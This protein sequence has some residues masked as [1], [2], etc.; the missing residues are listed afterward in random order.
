MTSRNYAIL[1]RLL[2]ALLTVGLALIPIIRAAAQEAAN[3]STAQPTKTAAADQQPEEV[4]LSPFVVSTD[5]D[6]GYGATNSISGSRVD[7]AIKDIPISINVI[8]SDFI[9]DIGATD[10]RSSLMYTSGVMLTTQNDLENTAGTYGS[11]YG[12]GGVNNPQGLTANINQVQFKIR[13]FITNNTLRDGFL[14]GSGTDAVNIERIEVVEGPNALLYGTG[15]FGG[16]VDYLTK[17]PSEVQQGAISVSYGTYSF[18]RSELDVTGPVSTANHIAYRLGASWESSE[19]NI[20]FQK[21][22]HY[23]IAPSLSWKPT[24]TTLVTLDTEYGKSKQNGY[25]FQA[26]RAAQ[27]TAGTP[28]N[29]DQLEAVAFYYP[30]GADPKTV[31]LSG[32]DTYNDQQESNIEIK[33][34]QQLLKESTYLP[35]VDFLLGYDRSYW[36]TQTQDV[37]GQITGPISPGNPG[38]NLSQTIV[39]AGVANGLGGQDVA[40]LSLVFGTFP[41]SV[42][43]YNWNQNRQSTN[44]EQE[45]AELTARKI[46]FEGKW[47]RVED[48]VLAGFSQL[49]NQVKRN[50]WTTYSPTPNLYSYKNPLDHSPI[51]FG[52]QGD[53]TADPPMFQNDLN[54]INKVWD[55]GYY[56]N[57]YL[58][59]LK[60]DRL[61]FMNGYRHDKVDAWSTDTT[62]AT[63]TS[64]P[65]VSLSRAKTSATKSYQNGV[66]IKVTKNLSIYGIKSEGLQ[67]NF[68]G[69]RN[70]V[71]GEPVGSDTAKSRE[72]GIKFDFFDGKISGTIAKYTITRT[73]WVN[74]PWYT[75][76][77]MGHAKFDPSKPIVYDLSSGFNALSAPDPR[78]PGVNPSSQG[79]PDQTDPAVVA[80]WN[81][82]LNAG[83]I[84]ALSPLTGTSQNP[85]S[86]IYINA[87][88]PTGAAYLDAVFDAEK[89][90]NNWPG[91]LYGGGVPYINNATLLDATG[92]NGNGAAAWQIIDQAKGYDGQ[93]LFTPN[94]NLQ[95]VLNGSVKATVNR[96]TLGQWQKYPYPQDRWAVWYFPNGS[97]GLFNQPLTVAYTDPNDTSTRTNTGVF[98][99]DD[100]PKYAFSMFANYKFL[101]GGLKG[102]T[103]G[104]GGNWHSQEAYFSGITHG[105]GQA[106]INTAGQPIVVYSPSQLLVNVFAK[107]AWK[108]GAHDQYVQLNVNNVLNDTKEYGL[109]FSSPITAKISYGIAF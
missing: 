39:T 65:S 76:A 54:N 13:G 10:L 57:N 62:F 1:D 12:P 79:A 109:I 92:F 42:T 84:T 71:T 105:S 102:L 25:G 3:P 32:P 74:Q 73:S 68:G 96:L 67:P 46:L 51:V 55:A 77:I 19:T 90:N 8:T 72:I 5:K 86:S 75:P 40:N 48:Q 69:L 106:E 37:N 16:V 91:W 15:N 17:L 63:P 81:A 41:N 11:P 95:I 61:I 6:N 33:V 24:P 56:L 103:V 99:G 9:K 27:G 49:F 88:T 47:Y 64:A 22:S 82:A 60:D 98:P 53:G 52:T 36:A 66:I 58:K 38:Y 4:R 35:R 45:R 87:S 85:G 59:L 2:T 31:N 93:I 7:T 101:T 78:L 70:G 44:R 18:M 23:F 14:R 29:N 43:K 107:Y 50:N 108:H 34:T 30:P 94:N 20:N 104:L 89:R 28:I 26:L 97:W 80:A 83:T 100:T 21:N